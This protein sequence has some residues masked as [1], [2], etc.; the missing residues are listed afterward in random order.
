VLREVTDEIMGTV[1]AMVAELR[2]EAPPEQPFVWRS[3]RDVR[4][5]A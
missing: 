4:R 2:E 1:T 5:T 3:G